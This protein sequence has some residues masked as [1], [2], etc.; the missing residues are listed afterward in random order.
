MHDGRPSGH[1][2][3]SGQGRYDL[4][5]STDFF[6][7]AFKAGGPVRSLAPIVAAAEGAGLRV[8]VVTRDRDLGDRSPFT[9]VPVGRVGTEGPLDILRI[10]ARS[11]RDLWLLCRLLCTV[12]VRC[13]YL[14]SLFSPVFTLLPLVALRMH[15]VKARRAVLAPRGECDAGAMAIHP[16]KKRIAVTLLRWSGCFRRVIFQATSDTEAKSI[17]EY[18]KVSAH[19]LIRSP[20]RSTLPLRESRP[21]SALRGRPL[22]LVYVG[23]VTPKKRLDAVLRALP[24][25]A[26]PVH[27]MIA[28]FEDDE[29]YGDL[30][31][32]LLSNVPHRHVVEW[33]L[34]VPHDAIVS[35]LDRSDAFVSLTAGENFGHAVVEAMRRGL[36]LVLSP[37][38]P[39]SE[40]VAQRGA[41]LVIDADPARG[42]ASALD[43]LADWSS[44]AWGSASEAALSI[45]TVLETSTPAADDQL[46]L[47]LGDNAFSPPYAT[48]QVVGP[49]RS[50]DQLR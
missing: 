38:T 17:S 28:G 43:T 21:G 7:P 31:R 5:V 14:N 49:L 3:L 33:T 1:R 35:L 29:S 19:D 24:L 37:H 32:D 18:L 12:D 6:S 45:A 23:R 50:P 41:G 39:W 36:P 10:D 25:V 42:V 46:R 47:I 15:L 20:N 44:G 26:H 48:D 9:A 16:V 40:S 11:R 2:P 27:L 8:L 13:L 22:R 34:A 30:C 4:V